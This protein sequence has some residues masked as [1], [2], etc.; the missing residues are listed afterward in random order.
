MKQFMENHD[1][2]MGALVERFGGRDESEIRGKVLDILS[3]PAFQL[4]TSEQQIKAAMGL[5]S[6]VRRMDMFLRMGELERQNMVWMII[7]DTFPSI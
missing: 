5:T 2:R 6:E 7:N 1:K 3:S 4:Y